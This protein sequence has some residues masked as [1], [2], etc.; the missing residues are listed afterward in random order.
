MSAADDER[1]MGR[2][3]GLALRAWGNTHPNPMVGSVL[4]EEGVSPSEAFHERD[5]GPARREDRPR[6]PHAQPAP[7]GDALRDPRAVLD[8]GPH[9]GLHRAIISAGIK[10]VVVGATDPNPEHAGRGFEV[11]RR[12]GVEVVS[13]VLGAEC[14]DMNLI[15][16]HWIV[17][18]EPL[19]AGKIAATLDGRIA[20][21]TANPAGSPA[22]PPGPTSTA[23]AG[24]FPPS[25]SGRGP[26]SRTTRSSR[27]G[28]PEP[29]STAPCASSSTGT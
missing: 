24:S 23:G 16:N 1:F 28:W 9:G 2:A 22:R 29:P 21:R 15:F 10:R 12:A 8:G 3:L 4:V 7:G 27:R 6:L 14:A 20:T 17:G 19:L 25:R 18:R 5:G 26:S 11:L 13:G